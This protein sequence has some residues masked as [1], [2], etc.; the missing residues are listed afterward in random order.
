MKNKRARDGKILR[1]TQYV[2]TVV[3]R[4]ALDLQG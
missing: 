1:V 4:K 2:V 3:V